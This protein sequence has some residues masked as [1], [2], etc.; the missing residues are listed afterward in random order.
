MKLRERIADYFLGGAL[1]SL[2]EDSRQ[3]SMSATHFREAL[4]EIEAGLNQHGWQALGSDNNEFSHAALKTIR[5]MALVMY[6]KNPL[7]QRGVKVQSFYVFGQGVTVHSR[8]E[9]ANEVIESFWCDLRNQ[10]ELTSSKALQDKD[11]EQ[12]LVGEHF[13]VLFTDALNGQVRVGT[14]DPDQVVGDPITNPDDDKEPWFYKRCWTAKTFDMATGQTATQARTAYY[15]DINYNP[16]RKPATIGG[17]P[18]FWDQPVLHI[19]TGGTSRMHRGVSEVFCQLDW[20]RAVTEFLQDRATVAKALSRFAMKAKAATKAGVAA[21]KKTTAAILGRPQ[22]DELDDVRVQ[23]RSGQMAVMAEG[24]DVEALNVKGATI[25]P[26]EVRRILLMVCAGKGL[27]ETFYGDASVGSLATAESLDWP[28]AL[29]MM[30]RQAFW[31]DVFRALI[32]YALI[33]AARAPRNPF[34]ATVTYNGNTP[35]IIGADGKPITI[36]VDFPPV[37]KEKT[38]DRLRAVDMAAKHIPDPREKFR[39]AYKAL[40]ED[41]IKDKLDEMF[42]EDGTPKYQPPAPPQAPVPA[43]EEKPAIIQ[44]VEE[45]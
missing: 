32:T 15:P 23:R 39:L 42:N 10:V 44:P 29:M 37:I 16:A 34:R 30:D 11:R 25:D 31:A 38:I 13:F 17:Y 26:N 22:P 7:I 6:L 19:K 1:S 20:A 9:A 3:A 27:P 43:K 12:Q 40:G 35:Q 8:D 18:V 21:I 4:A 28:T 5:R 36:E 45:Q 33:R 24:R 41:D 2:R 14:F